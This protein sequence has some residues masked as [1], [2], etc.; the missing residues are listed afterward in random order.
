MVTRDITGS[1][2][3]QENIDKLFLRQQIILSAIPDILMEVDANKVYTWANEAGLEFF[4]KDVIGKEASFYFEGEQ[5]VYDRVAPLFYGSEE[6]IY[7]ESWQRRQDGQK[8]LLAWWC[9]VLKDGEGNVTGALSSAR[10]ITERQQAEERL[11]QKSQLLKAINNVFYE[12]MRAKSEKE[13]ALICLDVALELTGS[14]F[15]FIGKITPENLFSTTA[16]NNPGWDVCLMPQD[17]AV[18]MIDNMVIRG[19]W[20]DVILNKQSLIVN[21]PA[22]Y[23]SRV[24]LPKDHPALTSFLGVP[25]MDQNKIIGMVAVANRK[26][27][28][29]NDIKQYL[30]ALSAALVE[31]IRLKQAEEIILRLNTNLEQRIA[32]RTADLSAKSEALERLNHMFVGR[33]LRMRELKARIAELE[34]YKV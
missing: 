29:T 34:R 24:G 26:S 28:Y 1:K 2:K 5:D 6:V 21:D 16:L 11:F 20:G 14:E 23:P 25:L 30:E 8:R 4:G 19:I 18:A 22:S 10:D 12:T 33:E 3:A 15:G 32:E 9:R 7:I 17:K 13:V 31:S 27:G